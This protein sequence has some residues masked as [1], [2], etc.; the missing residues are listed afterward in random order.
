MEVL[1]PRCCGLDVHKKSITACVLWAQEKGK[2]RK[3]K[4]RFTT[5]TRDLLRLADWLRECG[6]T[7]VAM[8][9]TGVYWEPVWNILDGQFE[10]LLV[11]AQHIKA[12]PGRKTDQKDSDWIADL[13]QHGL[14]R[15][16]FVPPQSTRELRDLTR[17]RVSLTQEIN[18]IANRIQKVFEDAN[19]K[20][21]SVATD[22]LG[23]SGRTMLEAMLGGEEDSSRLAEM[24]K[25]LLRN[26]MPEL[27]LALE[28]RMT[29]HHRFLLRQLYDHFCFT[30]AKLEEIEG[31]IDRRMRPFE[32]QVARLCTIPGV[33]RVTAWGL[34]AEIGRNMDQFPSAAHLA[35][36]ACLCPGNCESA[37]KRLSGKMRKEMD[38]GPTCL[39]D[40]LA[41]AIFRLWRRFALV[42]GEP[43]ITG[44]NAFSNIWP[45]SYTP[46]RHC[47]RVNGNRLTCWSSP[48][49]RNAWRCREKIR[50]RFAAFTP[51]G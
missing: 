36:W 39:T 32:E 43:S 30:E 28:G 40:E 19:I 23:A 44:R 47:V 14:L 42:T 12:V 5:F 48:V 7:H 17:Y 25:G 29:E 45:T 38:E 51:L 50:T 24:A 22:P 49:E 16:S 3:E 1:Y 2:S 41:R 33:D 21:A 37:G 6:V 8:E 4:R 10:V 18:R 20:L 35:S 9:S 11:N 27:K 13:L 15:G 46:G 26:K 34:L 31:E